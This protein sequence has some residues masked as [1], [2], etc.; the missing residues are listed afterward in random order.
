MPAKNDP[1]S[2]DI[3]VSENANTQHD[4]SL[5]E[6]LFLRFQYPTPEGKRTH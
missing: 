2:S 4:I 6:E 1:S 3:I 5:S